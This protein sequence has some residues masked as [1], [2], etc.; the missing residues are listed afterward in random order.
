MRGDPERG[1][2]STAFVSMPTLIPRMSHKRFIKA[3]SRH[4]R[5]TPRS[6]AKTKYG[7]SDQSTV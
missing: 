3:K 6:T 2:K 1:I 4:S 5:R 7:A